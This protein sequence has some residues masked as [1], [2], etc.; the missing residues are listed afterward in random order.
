MSRYLIRLAGLDPFG[1]FIHVDRPGKHALV[2][3]LMEEFRQMIVDRTVF[4]M[5]NQGMKLQLTDEGR[6]DDAT[7]KV[8]AERLQKRFESQ[9]PYAGKQHQL[10]VILQMQARHLATFVRGVGP[11]TPFVGRW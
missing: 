6:L 11:Y 3:D 9:E 4:A 8:L 7:R 10:R 1:G 5:L 2:F